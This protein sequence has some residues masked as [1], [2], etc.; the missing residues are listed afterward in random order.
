MRHEK[1]EKYIEMLEKAA[2]TVEFPPSPTPE[3]WSFTRFQ[4]LLQDV[5]GKYNLDEAWE[6]YEDAQEFGTSWS[7]TAYLPKP[8]HE[9]LGLTVRF[10]KQVRLNPRLPLGA[11]VQ[12][13]IEERDA[14]I[15]A[16]QAFVDRAGDEHLDP[17]KEPS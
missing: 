12:R 1:Y 3:R 10:F 15:K 8:L 11:Q 7:T 13:L 17:A 4:G 6:W 16:A 9:Q 2:P 14:F 5:L